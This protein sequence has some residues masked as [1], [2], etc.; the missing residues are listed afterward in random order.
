MREVCPRVV[1]RAYE[2]GGTPGVCPVA[3][4]DWGVWRAVAFVW[5]LRG[6]CSPLRGG[7]KQGEGVCGDGIGGA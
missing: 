5:P 4:T 3:L 7:M 2:G 1:E 6:H